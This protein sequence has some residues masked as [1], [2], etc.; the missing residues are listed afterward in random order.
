MFTKIQVHVLLTSKKPWKYLSWVSKS[1]TIS[2][3]WH[4]YYVKNK[5]N[6]LKSNFLKNSW[7]TIVW[8]QI[9]TEIIKQV[10]SLLIKGYLKVYRSLEIYSKIIIRNNKN[11]FFIKSRGIK[12]SRLLSSYFEVSL[13]NTKHRILW[14]CIWQ[15]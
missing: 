11:N 15:E 6:K 3:Q 12:M 10:K 8:K 2:L 4:G 7:F 5:M 14:L 1:Y 13:N 9:W